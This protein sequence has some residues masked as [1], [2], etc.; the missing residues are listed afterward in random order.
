MSGARVDSASAPASEAGEAERLLAL[1]VTKRQAGEHEEA[2]A[3]YAQAA[4][5]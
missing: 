2:A 3:L 5:L 1:G 4:A